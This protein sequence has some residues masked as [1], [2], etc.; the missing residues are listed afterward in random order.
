M[1]PAGTND[2]TAQGR[3]GFRPSRPPRDA[4]RAPTWQFRIETEAGTTALVQPPRRPGQVRLVVLLHGAGG[5]PERTLRPLRPQADQNRLLLV[6]PKSHGS[7]WDVI[8]GRFGPD[9]RA[10]DELLRRLHSAYR[11]EGCTLSGFSD[12]GSYALTMG[13]ANGDLFDSV[14]AFSPGFEAAGVANGRPRFFVSHGTGDQVLPID[15]CSRR[16]V[17]A[18]ERAGYDV[19]YREFEGGHQ[20]PPDVREDAIDWLVGTRTS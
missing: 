15:R 16:L 17:P 12:G 14:I 4:D 10:M 5:N 7:T 3:L 2:A 1:A 6:A 19:T 9:V 11:V 8:T 18:L 20:V 13:I